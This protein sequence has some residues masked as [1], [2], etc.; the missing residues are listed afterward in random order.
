MCTRTPLWRSTRRPEMLHSPGPEGQDSRRGGPGWS[1]PDGYYVSYV[2]LSVVYIRNTPRQRTGAKRRPRRRGGVPKAARPVRR[3]HSPRGGVAPLSSGA[4]LREIRGR[5]VCR[6]ADMH[7]FI[8][9]EVSMMFGPEVTKKGR[10]PANFG[11]SP[12]HALR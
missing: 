10:S 12:F 3:A 5:C 4:T 8:S 9:G 7:T 1:Y 6:T 11:E 2:Q